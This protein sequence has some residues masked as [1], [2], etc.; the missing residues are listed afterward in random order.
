MGRG[1]SFIP[2]HI[3]CSIVPGPFVEKTVPSPSDRLGTFVEN[4][5]TVNVRVYFCTLIS[6]HL[7]VC[8]SM[9]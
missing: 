6:V 5:L 4:H 3:G 7:Y 1:S 2:L 9:S 8:P